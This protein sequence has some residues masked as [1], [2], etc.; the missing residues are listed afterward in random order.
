MEKYELLKKI[1]KI[2]IISYV[3]ECGVKLGSWCDRQRTDKKKDKLSKDKIKLLE[4]I[5]G[6]FW[7][8]EQLWMNN[9]ELLKI[10][11]EPPKHSYITECGVKLG[12]WCQTQRTNKKNG[13]LS[14]ERIELLEK[15]P[16]WFWDSDQLWMNNYELL[17]ILNKTPK[18]SY[19][20]ECGVNLGKWCDRQRI[21]KKKGK[22]LKDKI[23][24]LEKI[25]GWY[26]YG[27]QKL[28]KDMSKPE[29]KPKKEKKETKEQKTQRIQ[30][31]LSILHKEYKTKNSQNLNTYFKE[32]PDKWK[33]YHKISKENEKSF[34]EEEIPRNKMIKY[35]ED[36]S[37]KKKKVI[38]DLGC[39]FAEINQHFK[40]NSRFE[41]HNF[42]HHSEN[43]L[44]ISRDIKNT[45][46]D[47]YSI[48][49][50]IL[51]LV[52]WGSNCKDYI[53]EAYR[54]LDNGGILLIAEPYKRWNK[55]LDDEGKPINE[56]VKLLKEYK[57]NILECIENKFMFIKCVKCE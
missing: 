23:D 39:G 5:P 24:L 57:F 34:E 7:D 40:D 48:D 3:S 46:L 10:L 32:N 36:L 18:R 37:G 6:W 42:D 29:I 27:N 41:F 33:D 4:K 26:W 8:L 13:K 47:D 52:M 19:T 9:Y 50:A 49:I 38:A 43:N 51:S 21:D 11:K 35:L 54:I 55:N 53:K 14:Q 12:M 56:L 16:G 31:E 45:E 17:K 15:I 20:T 44:V 22:L 2:P 28:K 1:K 25:P 30:S